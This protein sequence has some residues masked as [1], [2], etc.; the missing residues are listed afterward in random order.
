MTSKGVLH[1]LDLFSG[2]GGITKALDGYVRPVAYCEIEPYARGVLLSRMHSGDLPLAPIWDDVSTL[3]GAMLPQ[4]DIIYGG[5]PCQDISCAGRREGL[6]GKRSGLFF[7][8]LRLVEEIRPIFIFL[9][10]VPNIR[11]KGL[12]EA[13]RQLSSRGFDCRWLC[14]SAEEMGAPHKRNRWFLLAHANSTDGRLQ[15]IE[16]AEGTEEILI[17]NDGPKKSMGYTRSGE[18]SP[19]T[20]KQRIVREVSENGTIDDNSGRS[21]PALANADGTRL[22]GDQFAQL[23][24]TEYSGKSSSKWWETEPNVGRVAYGIPNRMDRLRALGNAVVPQCAR[25]AF[26]RLIGLKCAE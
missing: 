13:I 26:E 25:E 9:E 8:I 2:I 21:S 7:E 19:G 14:L 18:R 23:Q 15:S 22:E 10:N 3:R 1:G 24:F 4:V 20:E 16:W 6:G 5:F 12:A 11:T 17:G